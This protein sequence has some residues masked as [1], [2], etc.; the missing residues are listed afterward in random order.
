M[1]TAFGCGLKSPPTRPR[2][3]LCIGRDFKSHPAHHHYIIKLTRPS[4]VFS[5]IE[6]HGRPPGTRL[7]LLSVHIHIHVY[8]LLS[9]H[10]HIHILYVHIHIHVYCVYIITCTN[11][12]VWKCLMHK[13]K[14]IQAGSSFASAN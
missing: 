3:P 11:C 5:D 13:G 7:G 2:G 12:C 1:D 4:Q 14:A 6:K 9:I 8:C 10:I